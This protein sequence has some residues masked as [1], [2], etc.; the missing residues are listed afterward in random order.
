MVIPQHHFA[1]LSAENV[2]QLKQGR[3]GV[4]PSRSVF[5]KTVLFHKLKILLLEDLADVGQLL[6]IP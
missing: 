2:C 4:R 3:D 1:I 6:Q 5:P